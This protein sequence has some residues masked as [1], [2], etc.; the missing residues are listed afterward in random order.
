MLSLN[1]PPW[2]LWMTQKATA[3]GNWWLAASSQQCA[4]SCITS[5]AE[6]LVKH[7]IIQVTQLP[8]SPD[9]VPCNFWLFPKLKSPLKEKRFQTIIEIQE[10]RMRQMMAIG[11]T[12]WGPK[13]PTWQGT[14][15]P[16]SYVQCF[17]YLVSSSIYVS[18]FHIIWLDT[19]WTEL[20]YKREIQYCMC[21]CIYIYTHTHTY[22]HT[23]TH[24]YI[25][26]ILWNWFLWLW[27]R[28]IQNCRAYQQARNS[29]RNLY[30]ILN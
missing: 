21:L 26:F 11:R 25:W 15:A 8:Y 23:H 9:F 5:H 4:H 29:G 24:I 3:M 10:K 6:F 13:V 12:V 22:I 14:E 18:I 20:V 1:T 27:N 17:L 7:Q 2:K 30:N 19:C 16:L 28:A